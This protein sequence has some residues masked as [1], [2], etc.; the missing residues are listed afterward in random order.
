MIIFKNKKKKANLY[1]AS[2]DTNIVIIEIDVQIRVLSIEIN[3]MC[4]LFDVHTKHVQNI[5]IDTSVWIP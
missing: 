5:L 1:C 3:L 4:D 2:H